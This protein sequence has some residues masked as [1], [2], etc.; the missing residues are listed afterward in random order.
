MRRRGSWALATVV[1][2]GLLTAGMPSSAALLGPPPASA[3]MDAVLTAALSGA[4][5]IRAVAI[6]GAT[7]T[8][9]QL[10]L[11]RTA[12][13]DA[14]AYSMLP[15]VAIQGPAVAITAVSHL[16]FVRALWG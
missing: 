14:T 5:A 4:G 15:M 9:A 3:P 16:P 7:A 6:L 1:V 13:V 10:T 12:G 2:A 11:L 8:P